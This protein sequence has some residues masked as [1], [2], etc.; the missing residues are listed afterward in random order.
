MQHVTGTLAFFGLAVFYGRKLPDF[1]G[2]GIA[3]AAVLILGI[4]IS[5]TTIL[6][7]SS[8]IKFIRP[9]KATVIYTLEPVAAAVFAYVL[10]GE[11]LD[12][13]GALAGC[14]L[15]LAAILLSAY[16]KHSTQLLKN[17][18]EYKYWQITADATKKDAMEQ[19]NSSFR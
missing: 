1:N 17:K 6:V 2:I 16:K 15:I 12:G 13:I 11:R 19:A 9:E 8:A 10:L 18:V 4:L 5:V 7:Q 14:L 3:T